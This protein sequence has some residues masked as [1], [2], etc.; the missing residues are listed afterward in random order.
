MRRILQVLA[1]GVLGTS[2]A[3]GC[4]A[5][6]PPPPTPTFVDEF[7][8]PA[9]TPPDATKWTHD[10]G[11]RGWG[12]GELQDYVASTDNAALD[13]NG[14]LVITARQVA[15]GN[16]AGSFTSAR[17]HTFGKFAQAY[18]H[19][20]VRMKMPV[21]QGVWPAFWVLGESCRQGG[22]WPQCGEIDVV[23]RLGAISNSV[24]AHAHGPGF[25]FGQA[26]TLRSPATDW[27]TYAI[28]WSTDEVS[29]SIDG[30]VRQTMR[31]EEIGPDGWVFTD[32]FFIIVNLAV[33][34]TKGSPSSAAQF[35][36]SVYYDYVRV[37]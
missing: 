30:V 21:V 18:G 20:E 4:L 28:D 23:E 13:G 32:P 35:P 3:A 5:P 29:W 24:H 9:G 17:L 11:A 26:L 15:P 12:N 22:T 33:G 10:V 27:H 37:W 6:P 2:V 19:F 8:G 1:V 31:R 36:I 14:N 25:H 34:G 7:N 16:E